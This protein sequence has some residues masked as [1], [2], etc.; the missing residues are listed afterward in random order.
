MIIF[1]IL[2]VGAIVFWAWSIFSAF[3]RENELLSNGCNGDCDQ[4]RK[5][6]SPEC[7]NAKRENQE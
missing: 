3:V 5:E 2:V 1:E 7:P 4:G 6:C